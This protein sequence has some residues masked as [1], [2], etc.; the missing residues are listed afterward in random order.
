MS[1][2]AEAAR[3]HSP[4]LLVLLGEYLGE[5][6]LGEDVAGFTSVSLLRQGRD[7]REL[8]PQV[9]PLLQ[10][11][12]R[13]K[14]KPTLESWLSEPQRVDFPSILEMEVEGLVVPMQAGEPLD[15]SRL[16]LIPRGVALGTAAGLDVFRVQTAE[17]VVAMSSIAF[18]IWTWSSA[19]PSL[20]ATCAAVASGAGVDVGEVL[21]ALSVDLPRLLLTGAALLD[22]AV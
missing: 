8:P 5:Y 17:S 2:Q 21:S 16:R 22:K 19:L 10:L 3:T 1:V 11:L 20:E 6:D 18:W 14:S 4:D 9:G 15:A 13:P 7:V 12:T